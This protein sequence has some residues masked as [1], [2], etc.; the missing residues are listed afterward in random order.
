MKIKRAH[1]TGLG[2][3]SALATGLV[4]YTQQNQ[5]GAED[6][7]TFAY[8]APRYLQ[9][10]VHPSPDELLNAAR[11][12]VRQPYGMPALGKAQRGWTVHVFLPL[13]QDMTTFNVIKQAWAERRVTAIPVQPW[14]MTGDTQ[15]AFADKVAE[16]KV[17]L[18]GN[19]GFKETAQF[20]P[21]YTKYLPP[22]ALK[23]TGHPLYGINFAAFPAISKYLDEHPEVQ[24]LFFMDGGGVSFFCQIIPKHCAK[25]VGNWVYLNTI[26]IT[27]HGLEYPGDLWNLVEEVIARPAASVSEG[28]ITDPQGTNVQWT[29]MPDQARR[30]ATYVKT[31]WTN[32]HLFVYPNATEATTM[33]G[34]VAGTGNHVGFMPLMKVYLDMHGRPI[35]IV[36]GGQHGDLFRYLVESPKLNNLGDGSPVCLPTFPECGYWFL[37]SDG[38]GTNPK[39]VRNYE[40]LVNGT[41]DLPNVW[42]R[43]RGGILHM[44]FSGVNQFPVTRENVEKAVATHGTVSQFNADPTPFAYAYA[45]NIPIGHTAHLHQYF[46]TIRWKLRDTGEWISV[47]EKGRI[48]AYDN[49]EV[50]ALASKYGDPATIFSYDWIPGIP[51]INTPG[52]FA[53]YA[54]DPWKWVAAEWAQMKSGTYKYFVL[55]YKMIKVPANE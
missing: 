42:E 15:Q 53:D 23:D 33:Q 4:G 51:G 46:P 52:S 49:P 9:T 38:L 17:M 37:G 14:E 19:E 10:L 47:V 7:Q 54:K 43:E 32:N 30:W 8:P 5:A 39:K 45:H 44:S 29:M 12:V 11:I 2:V 6:A 31:P 35:K 48:S 16:A 1:K 41:T 28:T 50:R 27:N 36:G 24:H 3:V 21:S 25:D 40:T 34:V 13:G 20:D 18:H 55:D 22:N 26:D